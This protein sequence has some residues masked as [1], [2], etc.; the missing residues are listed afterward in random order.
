MSAIIALATVEKPVSVMWEPRTQTEGGV[1]TVDL[2][3][4]LKQSDTV[5]AAMIEITLDGAE[6]EALRWS[7]EFISV[8]ELVAPDSELTV[9]EDPVTEE[10]DTEEPDT[11][12]SG[13]AKPHTAQPGRPAA[14]NATEKE[15]NDGNKN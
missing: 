10:P 1:V 6:A 4:S 9:T 13:E 11:A 2:S 3:A 5:A 15:K 8:D 7:G 12:D 14:P